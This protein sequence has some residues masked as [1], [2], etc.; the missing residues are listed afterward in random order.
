M[1]LR[2]VTSGGK[3]LNLA[4][5][6]I[7]P[8]VYHAIIW[9]RGCRT[10]ANKAANGEYDLWST[11]AER[12]TCG[13]EAND[14]EQISSVGGGELSNRSLKGSFFTNLDFDRNGV[15]SPETVD[16]ILNFD[17]DCVQSLQKCTLDFLP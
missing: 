16:W 11:A 4:V 3:W 1:S 7:V 13:R 14:R 8:H 2:T 17:I 10:Q 6:I 15:E 5:L 9:T 12:E